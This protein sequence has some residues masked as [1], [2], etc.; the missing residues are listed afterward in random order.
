VNPIRKLA[1][2]IEALLPLELPR[3]ERVLGL[4]LWIPETVLPAKRFRT[5]PL[6]ARAILDDLVP[7]DRVLDMGTG[8]GIVG[9]A[10]AR[11][12]ATVVAIDKNPAAV[13]AAR[14]NAMLNRV[15]I[16]VRE[17]D[18]YSALEAGEKFDVL[19][20]NPPFFQSPSEHA[21]ADALSDR[22]GLPIL[23]AFLAGA[24]RRLLAPGRILIAGSTHGALGRT[25]ELYA[26][27]GFTFR[28]ARSRERISERLVID[29]LF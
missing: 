16:D 6:L 20:F 28:T 24:R 9:L 23:A 3:Y 21:L 10:A 12:G 2:R 15:P 4:E 8:S 25:R 26:E 5:G 11:A 13:R 22:P 19:A 1:A 27:H 7:G 18:L 14:V 29:Q 17:G